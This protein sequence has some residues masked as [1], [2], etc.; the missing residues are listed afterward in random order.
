MRILLLAPC[1]LALAACQHTH[2]HAAPVTTG[3]TGPDTDSLVQVYFDRF[4]AHDWQALA[5]MYTDTAMM[6]DPTTGP[7]AVPMTRADIAAKYMELSGQ[8]ADVRDSVV[9]IRGGDGWVTV[10]FVSTGTAPDSTRFALPICTVFVLRNGLIAEDRTYY[11][12]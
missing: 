5:S 8:I 12:N 9:A 4:N 2:D 6:L 7:D 3:T 1:L 10:E 11:D